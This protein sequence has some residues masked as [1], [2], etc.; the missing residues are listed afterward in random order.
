MKKILSLI[1]TFVLVFSVVACSSTKENKN[2]V[3]KEKKQEDKKE[4]VEK[5]EVEK[6]AESVK[7]NKNL[8]GKELV[9][10]VFSKYKG[11]PDERTYRADVKAET[12]G[13][14]IKTKI[15]KNK[16]DYYY[17]SEFQGKTTIYLLIDK[18]GY[19]YSYVKGEKVGKKYENTPG[20]DFEFPTFDLSDEDGMP[21]EDDFEDLLDA[22]IEKYNGEEALY[23]E[24][25]D[26]DPDDGGSITKTWYSLAKRMPL[27]MTTI[28]GE[29]V[30]AD[31][32]VTN[33][34]IDK[35]FSSFMKVPSDVKFDEIK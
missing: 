22:R 25:E 24:Y 6:K 14:V 13:F 2:G 15:V 3:E 34:V 19:L 33:I 27:R 4:K 20:Q 1:I 29:K 35:D 23:I 10:E 30:I 9:K 32:E 28:K 7:L 17:E 31:L 12:E 18:D 8:K 16:K 11:N 5:K 21:D 26:N